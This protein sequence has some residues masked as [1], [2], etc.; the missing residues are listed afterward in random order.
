MQFLTINVDDCII[1]MR[2]K[3]MI[4]GGMMLC[5]LQKTYGNNTPILFED[6][7][8][9]SGYSRSRVNQLISSWIASKQLMRYSDGVFYIPTETPFGLSVIDDRQVINRKYIE[10]KNGRIGIYSGIKLFNLFGLTNQVPVNY[11]IV[12]NKETMRSREVLVG[13]SKIRLKKSRLTI[14]D[15][16]YKIYQLLEVLN[17]ID[18]K[19]E[20]AI[21]KIIDYAK[22]NQLKYRDILSYLQ[23]FPA[24]VA[25]NLNGTGLLNAII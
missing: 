5:E 11:E 25:K 3:K 6:I 24:K 8:K 14:D 19:D 10:N 23:F 16:N 2:L 7:L 22:K 17:Q 4:G 12:T 18:A 21:E 1:S 20:I 15:N 13:R 9:T